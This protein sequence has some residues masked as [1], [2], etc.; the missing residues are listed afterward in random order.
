MEDADSKR[1]S[2]AALFNKSGGFFVPLGTFE[3]YTIS[4]WTYRTEES[5]MA[6]GSN[7]QSLNNNFYLSYLFDEIE[8]TLS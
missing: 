5:K 4:F 2:N 3:E 6:I 1:G 8:V 7:S